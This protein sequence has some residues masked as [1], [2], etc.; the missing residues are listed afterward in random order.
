MTVVPPPVPVAI[1]SALLERRPDAASLE[2]Q[3]AGANEQLGIAKAA[4]YPA[5]SLSA[6]AGFESATLGKL[7]NWRSRFWSA[8]P[9]LAETVFEGGRRHAQVAFQQ[10]AR[11]PLNSRYAALDSAQG[12]STTLVQWSC[13]SRKTWYIFGASSIGTR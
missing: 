6:T 10:A 9:Q 2:R 4:Y 5:L 3:V 13:L 12:S 8:G 1:P 7:L 11:T